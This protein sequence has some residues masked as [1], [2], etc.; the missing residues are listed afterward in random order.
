MVALLHLGTALLFHLFELLLL[1]GGHQGFELPVRVLHRLLHLLAEFFSEG[2][3]LLV[4]LLEDR[5][6]LLLLALGQ[7]QL[8]TESVEAALCTPPVMA[9]TIA[10]MVPH[11]M[12]GGGLRCGCR[13]I[14][15]RG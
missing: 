10:A 9:M 6:H 13:G 4:L 15:G 7:I 12:G 14:R 3:H 8:F 11:S 1:R 2:L 5:Q